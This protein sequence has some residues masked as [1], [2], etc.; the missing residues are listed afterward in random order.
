MTFVLLC[1][2]FAKFVCF[3]LIKVRLQFFSLSYCSQGSRSKITGVA[4]HSFL[5]WG[6][7]TITDSMDMNHSRLQEIVKDREAWRAAVHGGHKM[8]DTTYWLNNKPLF[9]S[10]LSHAHSLLTY[11]RPQ[12]TCHFPWS[13]AAEEGCRCTPNG[14][15]H[16]RILVGLAPPQGAHPPEEEPD[17]G[18][19]C[20]CCSRNAVLKFWLQLL[21]ASA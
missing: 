15:N 5:H 2:W 14:S 6:W 13:L 1:S 11:Q 7:N 18:W 19:V 16:I 3:L 10:I 17:T 8:S 21:L 9:G 12:G 20:R 4:C